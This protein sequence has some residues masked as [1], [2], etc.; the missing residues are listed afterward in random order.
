MHWRHIWHLATHIKTFKQ[1]PRDIEYTR[2]CQTTFGNIS[3]RYSQYLCIKTIIGYIIF[4]CLRK[5]LY[6]I[7][8][9]V[10]WH[11]YLIYVYFSL[12]S[13]HGL[14]KCTI[15]VIYVGY[16]W[17]TN[18]LHQGSSD[19]F[20]V[21]LHIPYGRHMPAARA[22]QGDCQW[23]KETAKIPTAHMHLQWILTEAILNYIQTSQSQ[24]ADASQLKAMSHTPLTVLPN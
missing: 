1:S 9:N 7:S 17:F 20:T 5:M 12:S 6:N 14:C 23:P 21:P 11:N 16:E 18:Y 15:C 24:K 13:G 3:R 2:K 22:V 8:V 4:G 19:S 10:I